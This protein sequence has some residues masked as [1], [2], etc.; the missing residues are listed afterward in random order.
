MTDEF[1]ASCLQ[2]EGE[3]RATDKAIY[4]IT[5]AG[6]RVARWGIHGSHPLGSTTDG[7]SSSKENPH[8][9]RYQ[10][11][12]VPGGGGGGLND[13]DVELVSSLRLSDKARAEF[14]EADLKT[15]G[16]FN[17]LKESHTTKLQQILEEPALRSLFREFLRLNFCEENLNFWQDVQDFK[18]RFS[19][20]S[21][22]AAGPPGE[23]SKGISSTMERHN[24][25]LI[26]MAFIMYVCSQFPLL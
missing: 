7:V 3:F 8:D 18:K 4:R 15:N 17:A 2:S 20:T 5:D 21:S 6:A 22:A 23:G 14:L 19:T 24:Q 9:E 12:R 25:G 1:S 26:A 13:A 10:G 16:G 11:L